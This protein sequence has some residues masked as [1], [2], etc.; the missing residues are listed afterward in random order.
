MTEND[1]EKF[2]EG[3]AGIYG[4]YDKE[5]NTFVLDIW[6]NALKI[7]DLPAIIQAFNRHV[8][9]TES[10]K[11]LP[12]PADIIRMLRGST[13]DLA[14]V[15][16]A[17]VDWALRHR[18]TYVDVVF[19][20]LLIHRVL[21]DM[22]GWISLG[23]KIEDELPFVAREFENRYR[24][25]RERSEIPEYP[26]VLIGIANAY[27]RAKGHKLESLVM[28]GNEDACKRVIAGGTDKPIIG[29][30]NAGESAVDLKLAFSSNR[31]DKKK[32]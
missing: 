19:P 16:W 13:Q 9:N 32:A 10:G 23:T 28:I 26:A 20:D 5:I 29:F 2:R 31:D 17:K 18:G 3:L 24:G 7:Y 22:G 15:A 21:H 1:F 12:K 30:K 11:W 6:W 4:F 27:N 25:F 8:I 14:L